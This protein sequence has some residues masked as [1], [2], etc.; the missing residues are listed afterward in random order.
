MLSRATE[1]LAS[2]GFGET[3]SQFLHWLLSEKMG[4]TVLLAVSVA[5]LALILL[6]KAVFK[7]IKVAAILAIVALAVW[8]GGKVSGDWERYKTRL[9]ACLEEI[10]GMENPFK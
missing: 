8:Y 6:A 9:H 7:I 3:A 4:L 10:K 1:W 2:Q 5:L